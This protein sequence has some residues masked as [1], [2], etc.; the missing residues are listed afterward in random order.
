MIRTDRNEKKLAEISATLRKFFSDFLGIKYQFTYDE[1]KSELKKA[2]IEK[3]VREKTEKFFHEMERIQY[4]GS[5]VTDADIERISA[6]AYGVIQRISGYVE[7]KKE[8]QPVTMTDKML[9]KVENLTGIS[10]N[11]RKKN[12]PPAPRPET[13]KN[14]SGGKETRNLENAG[15][16]HEKHIHKPMASSQRVTD[17]HNHKE[18]EAPPAEQLPEV[19]GEAE[20]AEKPDAGQQPGP[21]TGPGKEPPIASARPTEKTAKAAPPGEK[22]ETELVG[23][24]VRRLLEDIEGFAGK[25]VR[26]NGEIEFITKIFET[27]D[28]WYMFKD[29]TGK[30]T[31]V[32]KITGKYSG[33]GALIGV[34]KKTIMGE[35]FLV[36]EA[37]G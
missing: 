15:K 33:E 8:E 28:Y 29:H 6:E 36:I 11:F 20:P 34:A 30:I 19:G 10:I 4:G 21:E 17:G 14:D 37:F 3:P 13:A 18:P 25:T 27:K 31:A 35:P 9:K 23:T 1:L 2:S 7:S 5:S 24:T 26:L 22:Q 32:S 16:T 12:P